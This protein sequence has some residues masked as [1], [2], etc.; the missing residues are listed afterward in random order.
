MPYDYACA[1]SG[2]GTYVAREAG[3]HLYLACGHTAARN[4]HPGRPVTWSGWRDGEYVTLELTGWRFVPAG[5]M[6]S[7]HVWF[8]TTL[9]LLLVLSLWHPGAAVASSSIRVESARGSSRTY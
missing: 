2:A 7:A 5:D 4:P 1:V 8:D 9:L 3:G 6:D